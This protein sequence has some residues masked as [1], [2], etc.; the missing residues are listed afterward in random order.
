M[1]LWTINYTPNAGGPQIEWFPMKH[2]AEAR[3]AEL[4]KEPESPVE[5]EVKSEEV[6]TTRSEMCA[7]LNFR[8]VGCWM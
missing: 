5:I 3:R 2:L 8:S 1:K 6:P 7:W 4:L